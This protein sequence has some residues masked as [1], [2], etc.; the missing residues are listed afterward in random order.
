MKEIYAKFTCIAG[1]KRA[2]MN[3]VTES[4]VEFGPLFLLL[5]FHM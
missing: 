1:T 2:T 4:T 3:V 5:T